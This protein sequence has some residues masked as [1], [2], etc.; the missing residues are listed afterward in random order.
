M[1]YS[2][3]PLEGLTGYAYRAVHRSFFPHDIDHYYAPFLATKQNRPFTSR[4]LRD[5]IPAHNEGVPLVPQLLTNR[6]EDFIRAAKELAT[7]GY[8]EINFNLG[9]PSPT[10]AAKGKGSGFLAK[11]QELDAFFAE[12]F[13]ADI[14][15][16]SVK[17][18]IGLES[19]DEFSALLDIY[20]H[21]PIKE[22]IIH[23]R[24]KSDYYRNPPDLTVFREALSRSVYPVCYNGN[25]FTADD[26]HAFSAE[27]PTVD[28]VMIGRGLLANPALISEIN[29]TGMLDTALMRE[30]H[31]ALYAA[32]RR[33]IHGE[34]N[35][36][37]AM[38]EI[39]FYFITM[40]EDAAKYAKK[41][42]KT[43][44]LSDYEEAVS[45]LFREREVVHSRVRF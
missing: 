18:R 7:L 23:P 19:A 35:V 6:A 25:L 16:V 17:T 37:F 45:A 29:G 22:L 41:I 5:L 20:N 34:R 3:A 44:H 21:Y 10:V 42:R 9:C 12:I 26:V 27:F 11:P 2:F 38:K 43:E 28:A 4:E 24:T 39:W 14:P 31:E 1:N 36:L 32:Y 8:D 33:T 30:F 13:S 15:A 40:F